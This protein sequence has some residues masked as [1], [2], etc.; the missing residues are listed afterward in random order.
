M[1]A[2]PPDHVFV[3]S[4]LSRQAVGE[5]AK[6]TKLSSLGLV[7]LEIGDEGARALAS[8]SNLTSL[9]LGNNGIGGEGARALASLSKLTSLHLRNN[10]IGAEGAR[11]LASLSNLTSL[12]LGDNGIGGEGARALASLSK[13]TSLHLWNNRIGAEGARALAS[14]S[15]LTSL[16]LGNNRIGAEGARALASL[17]NLTS[18]NLR[19]NKIGDKGARALAS[20][21]KL[22]SLHLDYNEIGVEGARALASLP[23]L[24][25]LHLDS[26]GIGAEG[27]RALASLS[28]LSSLDLGD[29]G[30][31]DE[32][33]RALASL[34]N[35]TSLNLGDNGIGDEGARALLE[36]WVDRPAAKNLTTLSLRN[37]GDL[38]SVLPDEALNTADAQAILAA[39]RRYRTAAKQEKL[40]ALN[41]AKLLV[42]GNEA[43]GKTSLIRY[44]VENE[45]RDPNEKKTPGTA[46]HEHID[47]RPWLTGQG[48]VTLNIWD[49]G[50]QEIIHGTHRFFLTARSLYLL[51]LEDRREDDRSVYDW[52]KIIRNRGQN[53]PV[54]VV[55]NKS[56][57]GKEDLRLDETTLQRTYPS[58]VDFVRTSCDETEFAAKSIQGLR[59]L[60]ANTLAQ[61][62]RLKH[63]RDRVPQAWLRVKDAVTK[64]A[65]EER[66]LEQS[67]FV[68]LCEQPGGTAGETGSAV[69]DADE[70]RALLRTLHELGV[71]V[72]HG[73]E[74]D[75]PSA[76]REINLLDPNW[77][78]G[79]IYTILNSPTVRDQEGEFSR[80]QLR[81]L[82]DPA[83]YPDHWHEFILDMM[84]D[85]DMGLCFR[86]HDHKEERYL[87][88]EALP[89]SGPDYAGIW[90]ADS[91]RFRFHYEFLPR[92]LIPRFIVQTHRNLTDN[93][94]RWRT[95]VLLKASGCKILVRRDGDKSLI[96]IVVSGPVG[97][98][99]GALNVVLNDLEYVHKLNPEIGPDPRVPLPRQPEVSVS[100][101][102]LLHMEL[103]NGPGYELHP[104]GANRPYTV[105]ELLD[106]VRR[107]R[108]GDAE[109]ETSVTN[110]TV[111]IGNG[112]QFHGDFAVGKKIQDS[113]NKAQASSSNDELKALLGQLAGEVAKVAEKMP[114]ED[115]TDLA[116]DLESFTKE[117]TKSQP[118]LTRW[119]SVAERIGEAAQTAGQIGTTVVTVLDQLRPLLLG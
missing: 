13:L 58:I 8:L 74:R 52:L 57:N 86:L 79:A 108:P 37:N 44:L 33:A 61:D 20:L 114:T 64:M 99:R 56:D 12:H 81:G 50:G 67:T 72:A 93:P 43:V 63:I 71:V 18:L 26:N 82:L 53:S 32:G 3:V 68:R 36:A 98:R 41:E 30:I 54:I 106:G 69:T 24:T 25:S 51:V 4:G 59:E 35:L 60:I 45:P 91:L 109:K 23:K 27:A 34:S 95:G 47:T 28:N 102:H 87:L 15:K 16:D 112:V 62:E 75:A 40:R 116:D 2:L 100:Y 73:L 10:G 105:H 22:T 65:R 101:E 118:K 115:A 17:S 7:D 117:A 103:L 76:K 96:D 29:N 89:P 84:Q 119:E 5:L 80:A 85:D 21:S 46:I 113:F 90:P 94:T 6:L 111:N 31:G 48:G 104:E 14:L 88:P 9:D 19:S 39:Y 78:T 11:A 107:D 92:R 110:I 97:R 49:F 38:S 66:V 77:L 83:L 42:I 55:I 1:L 70:Q